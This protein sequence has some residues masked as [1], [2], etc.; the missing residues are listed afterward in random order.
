MTVREHLAQAHTQHAEHCIAQGKCHEAMSDI[1]KNL[2]AHHKTKADADAAQ[3]HDDLAVEHTKC[4]DSLAKC[5][6]YHVG[7]AK[8]MSKA[9]EPD[10]N[11]ILPT[12]VQAINRDPGRR[13]TVTA[14]PR[15]GSPNPDAFQ[16]NFEKV[17][18]SVRRFAELPEN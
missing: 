7:C 16:K 8:E 6:E 4:A 2:A 10:L 12:D 18:D 11:K 5:A 3:M 15:T 13:S 14:V 9:A 1:H 17:P